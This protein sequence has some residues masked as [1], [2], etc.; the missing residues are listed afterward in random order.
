MGAVFAA[1]FLQTPIQLFS[2]H[3]G[4]PHSMSIKLLLQCLSRC[5]FLLV[6]GCQTPHAKSGV[7]DLMEGLGRKGIMYLFGVAVPDRGETMGKGSS[8]CE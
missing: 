2:R 7:W 5:S 3:I 4:H 6:S 8:P 1:A